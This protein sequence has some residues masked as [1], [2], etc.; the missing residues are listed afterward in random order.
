M[1]RPGWMSVLALAFALIAVPAFGQGGTTSATLSGVVT[2]DQ[3]AVVP[4]ATI[5]LTN[6]N[7]NEVVVPVA[8]NDRG[9]YS[10]AAVSPGTYVLKVTMPSFKT[11]EVEIRIQGGVN[12]T[13]NVKLE[14][15]KI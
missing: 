7:T 6:K 3:N 13:Q 9:T 10:F 14:I 5:L 12:S 4:G 2:D 8:T 11:T 15:G 1:S